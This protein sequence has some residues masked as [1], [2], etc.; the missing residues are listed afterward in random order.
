ML[1]GNL[2]IGLHEQIRL[3]PYIEQSLAV[4]LEVLSKRRRLATAEEAD[5]GGRRPQRPGLTR[6]FVTH[7]ATQMLMTITLPTRELK[8]SQNVVAPTGIIKFPDDLR[9]IEDPRC[10]T[11]V[12]QFE[13]GLDTLSGSAAGNWGS[14]VDRMNFIVDFFRSHQQNKH[15]FE[16]PFTEAQVQVID[17]G[18]MPGGSL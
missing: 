14:L 5:G 15:L 18:Q 3:Q 11:L 16:P 7:A 6:L 10:R 9:S 4:P 12:R 1:Q 13:T 2:L 8:L 17:A